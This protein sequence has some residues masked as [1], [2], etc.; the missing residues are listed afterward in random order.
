MTGG[1]ALVLL[2]EPAAVP[3]VP[4]V[5]AAPTEAPAIAVV[6]NLTLG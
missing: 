2:G 1:V 5:P 6:G 4:A 3:A